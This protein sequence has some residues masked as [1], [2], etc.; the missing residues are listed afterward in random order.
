MSDEDLLDLWETA[1][2]FAHA[3]DGTK[4]PIQNAKEANEFGKAIIKLIEEYKSLV[5]R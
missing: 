1:Y 3:V 4:S 2:I 5:K